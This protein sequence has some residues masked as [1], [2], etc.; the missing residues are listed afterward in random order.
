M[1]THSR[2]LSA[3]SQDVDYVELGRI[4]KNGTEVKV[5]I[6][7]RSNAYKFQ[8]HAEAY[9]WSHVD[10]TWNLAYSINPAAMATKEGLSYMPRSKAPTVRDFQD[11]RDT[12]VRQ[13]N[14]ILS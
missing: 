1:Y 10:H 5:K 11:D 6:D 14:F 9:V 2:E 4:E 3:G 12:L 13:V 7:I 8:C